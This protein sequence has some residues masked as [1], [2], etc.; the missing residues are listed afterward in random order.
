MSWLSTV[1]GW[2]RPVRFRRLAGGRGPAAGDHP[3]PSGQP[4]TVIT[5]DTDDVTSVASAPDASSAFPL[6][7]AALDEPEGVG[8]LPPPGAGLRRSSSVLAVVPHRESASWLAGCLDSLLRGTR[9]PDGIVV[10]DDASST[11][12]VDVVRRFPAVT[13][14][15]AA[16][17][18]GP[19]RLVQ[20]VIEQTGYDAYLFQDADDWSTP[21]RLELLLAEA[22]RTGAELIGCQAYRVLCDEGEVVPVTYPLDVNAALVSWPTWYALLHP[23]SLVARDLVIRIGGFATGLKFGGDLEFLHRA[24]HSARVVNIPQFAYLKRVHG[25]ALTA[26]PETGLT[27]RARKA[28]QQAENDRARALAAHVDARQEPDLRPMTV[29]GRI[30]LT[31]L[32]GPKLRSAVAGTWP[33]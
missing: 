19:Y 1:D 9:P 17:N 31:H 7:A 5:H 27:S 12:P 24:A 13:L 3:P 28:F 26:H 11:P 4:A 6:T 16:E 32:S 23:T 18:V 21:D 15:A 30:P 22:E 2:L 20:A 29:A 25:D 10:V 33:L 8:T 14:L